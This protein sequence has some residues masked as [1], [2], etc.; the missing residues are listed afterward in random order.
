MI[1]MNRKKMWPKY[2]NSLFE[3]GEWYDFLVDWCNIECEE[4]EMIREFAHPQRR[5]TKNVDQIMKQIQYYGVHQRD[6]VY[7]TVY[8]F[9]DMD[10]EWERRKRPYYPS[11]YIDKL[12]WETDAKRTITK[13]G[14]KREIDF[15][16]ER[17]YKD[18]MAIHDMI[19]QCELFRRRKCA[20]IYS[21][22]GFHLY[23]ELDY[24]KW[25]NTWNAKD[26]RDEMLSIRQHIIF[27]EDVKHNDMLT[28][29]L[30][31][32][33]TLDPTGF[34]DVARVTRI[35]WSLHPRRLVQVIPIIPGEP[36]KD[37]IKRAG[38]WQKPSS[39]IYS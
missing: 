5:Y 7:L 22:G 28:R 38:E 8:E 33:P 13:D 35:P 6:S 31:D 9:D 19:K 14:V 16:L 32:Y 25:G 30:D 10:E 4:T 3:D 24:D 12:W 23:Q 26:T 11:V 20:M 34:G 39:I 18:I 29:L 1:D 37:I 27:G 17:S 15:G 2:R 36:L 21:G